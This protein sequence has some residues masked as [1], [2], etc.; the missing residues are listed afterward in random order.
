[1]IMVGSE[2]REPP[3][4]A[5]DVG[6]W[7]EAGGVEGIEVVSVT[8]VDVIALVVCFLTGRRIPL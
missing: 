7:P 8:E 1:M 4:F 2:M 3:A 5:V 6:S